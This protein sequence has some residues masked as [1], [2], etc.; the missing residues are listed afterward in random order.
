MDEIIQANPEQ[1]SIHEEH[2]R[3]GLPKNL[4]YAVNLS[5]TAFACYYFDYLTQENYRRFS[6]KAHKRSELVAM[7][8]GPEAGLEFQQ[9]YSSPDGKSGQGALRPNDITS[10]AMFQTA[11]V[12]SAEKR[13]A[14][15][16]ST[17]RGW[18]FARWGARYL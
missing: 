8:L 5:R 14:G 2:A 13:V 18:S 11:V 16:T 7:Q 17:R 12:R 1:R 3:L 15:Q 6:A 4:T 10:E 9:Q